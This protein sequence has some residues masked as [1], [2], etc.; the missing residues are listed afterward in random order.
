[1]LGT[2]YRFTTQSLLLIFLS[3]A[4]AT[5]QTTFGSLEGVVV[6]Q[7]DARVS[8]ASITVINLETNIARMVITDDRGFYRV[9]N[10]AV[11]I[12]T[13]KAQRSGFATA[14]ENVV[15]LEINQTRVVNLLLKVSGPEETIAVQSGALT[16]NTVTSDLGQ[17][18]DN[19]RVLDLPLNGRSF[20]QLVSILP[21]AIDGGFRGYAV[22]G[23]RPGGNNFLLNGTDANNNYFPENVSGRSGVTFTSLGISSIEDIQEFRVATNTYSAEYGRTSG[24]QVSV[25]TKSGTNQIHGSAFEFFRDTPLQARDYFSDRTKPKPEFRRNQFGG[26]LGGPISK[27]RTFFFSSYEG[28]RERVPQTMN[29]TV[30]TQLFRQRTP[31]V[32]QP[33]LSYIPLPSEPKINSDGTADPFV[34]FR[35]VST[36]QITSED[37]VSANINHEFSRNDS[38]GVH[39]HIDD[40]TF[41]RAGLLNSLVTGAQYSRN[42]LANITHNHIFSGAMLNEFRAGLNRGTRKFFYDPFGITGYPADLVSATVT[43]LNSDVGNPGGHSYY[44]TTTYQVV[45]NLSWTRRAHR[46]RVGADIRRVGEVFDSGGT[47]T[48]SYLSFEDFFN[49]RPDRVVLKS[50]NPS[51]SF[52]I[53]NTD[54]YIQDDVRLASRLN[55]NLGL[56]Y[57][58]NTPLSERHLQQSNFNISSGTLEVGKPLYRSDKNNFA[59]R[60]GFAWDVVGNGK[61]VL[62]SAYGVFYDS[63]NPGQFVFQAVNP[64]FAPMITVVRALNPDLTYPLPGSY[65]QSQLTSTVY[66]FAPDAAQPLVQQFNLNLQRQLGTDTVVEVGYVGNRSVHLVRNRDIN[67][68]DPVLRRRPDPRFASIIIRETSAQSWYHAFQAN[69]NRRFRKGL[70][71]QI[72]Y[73]WGHMTDDASSSNDNGQNMAWLSGEYADSDFDR[74]HNLVTNFVYELPF[75][76]NAA[77]SRWTSLLNAVAGGWQINGIGIYRTALPFTLR[78]GRDVRGDGSA[79]TQRVNRVSGVSPYQPNP[80][81]NLYLNL[82]A[83]ALPDP[84]QYGNVGRNTLRGFDYQLLD[85]SIFKNFPAPWFG[86]EK[87]SLQFRA[88]MF[89]VFNH[90]NLGTPDSNFSSSTFGRISSTVGNLSLNNPT[91]STMRQIQ[92]ALKFMF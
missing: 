52:A 22:N 45:D 70:A 91:G 7:S 34:G 89:N 2:R 49:N 83:F 64:P 51:K 67:R 25:V 54:L 53:T 9:P 58:Y 33:F 24:A 8:G 12:Y 29:G 41:T 39:Y 6:D 30:P 59:P 47:K 62:R 11:G 31:G 78:S 26:S 74:R 57:E 3:V 15:P 61:T 21:G 28:L 82:A 40:G 72:S 17:V 18:I 1:M 79:S 14:A 75:R 42:Q 76:R 86:N 68:I 55:V 50:N 73:T 92:L 63:L 32:F 13:V 44:P 23:S 69:L 85:F 4:L 81:P 71:A 80:S 10:L 46:L 16:V 88:E 36:P 43:G 5:A 87:S 56:R 27:G 84:G 66:G 77:D 19:K 90:P 35:S 38:V 37:V 20:E 48:A 65:N 60:I